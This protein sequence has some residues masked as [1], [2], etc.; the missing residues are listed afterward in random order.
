MKLFAHAIL[1]AA[2]AAGCFIPQVSAMDTLNSSLGSSASG[3]LDGAILMSTLRAL[4]YQPR[5]AGKD[6]YS[7][8]M[9]YNN[10]TY[11][12]DTV[13]SESKTMFY[14]QTPLVNV[15]K[16]SASGLAVLK[17]SAAVT[18]Y[19]FAVMNDTL[20]LI[21]GYDNRGLTREHIHQGVDDLLR[22]A[23]KTRDLWQ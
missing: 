4:G 21:R 19:F 5:D 13:I 9:V 17:R 22:A 7:F 6:V 10:V 14:I 2:L 20:Y 16:V 1:G 8:G 12:V 18:P 3:P 15:N 23:D 11:S